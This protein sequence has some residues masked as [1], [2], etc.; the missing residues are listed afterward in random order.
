MNADKNRYLIGVHRRPISF[1]GI[2]EDPLTLGEYYFYSFLGSA[3]LLH[4][5]ISNHVAGDASQPDSEALKFHGEALMVHA[6]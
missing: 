3:R 2:F 6:E 4:Q 5:D 1:S